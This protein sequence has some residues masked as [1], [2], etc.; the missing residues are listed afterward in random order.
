MLENE[1]G[2]IDWFLYDISILDFPVFGFVLGFSLGAGPKGVLCIAK[3]G[4][5]LLWFL[6]FAFVAPM[7]LQAFS[8]L[9]PL[10][11]VNIG[12]LWALAGA[13]ALRCMNGTH[14]VVPEAGGGPRHKISAMPE[15]LRFHL[16]IWGGTYLLNVGIFFAYIVYTWVEMASASHTASF[17]ISFYD[18]FQ[19]FIACFIWPLASALLPL[20]YFS[21]FPMFRLIVIP[22][23]VGLA[24]LIC[25]GIRVRKAWPF[26]GVSISLCL[27]W[28]ACTIY[29]ALHMQELFF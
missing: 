8:A 6:A 11:F 13:H 1:G 27:V 7:L 28:M 3:S 21:H 2:P 23:G 4:K 9:G 26:L 19:M 24:A 18:I 16:K 17:G 12:L 5:A 22:L 25:E 14:N 20:N 15:N 10:I 29:A